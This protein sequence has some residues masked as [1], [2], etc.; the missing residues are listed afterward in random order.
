MSDWKIGQKVEA[1]RRASQPARRAV[2]EPSGRRWIPVT[3]KPQAEGATEKRITDLGYF[4]YVP[5][6]TVSIRDPK[7]HRA[8]IS[9]K[10]PLFARVLFAQVDLHVDPWGDIDR[11][12][13]VRGIIRMAGNPATVPDALVHEMRKRE[14]LNFG[15]PYRKLSGAPSVPF[16]T[17]DRVRVT[18]GPFSGFFGSITAVDANQRITILIELLGRFVPLEN[19][20]ADQIE[21]A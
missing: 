12:V 6:F 16:K 15:L 3:T 8:Y 5:R 14:G 21:G 17:N 1:I 20:E 9:V 11:L 4:A 19:L 7:K 2:S 18:D 13:G 10:R